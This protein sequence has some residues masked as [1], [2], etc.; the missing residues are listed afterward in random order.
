MSKVQAMDTFSKPSLPLKI[1]RKEMR[2]RRA[3]REHLRR[4]AEGG[5][6]TKDNL[7]LACNGCNSSR[8]VIPPNDW[9]DIRLGIKDGLS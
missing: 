3:T 4:R 1:K 5:I 8:G 2:M 6:R 9:R 7:V